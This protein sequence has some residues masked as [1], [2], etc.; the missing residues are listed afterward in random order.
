V[1][2]F[3]VIAALLLALAPRVAHACGASGPGGIGVG[4]S[5]EEHAEETRAHWRVG[6][7]YAYTS[8]SVT[9][10]S[11]RRADEQR[12]TAVATL[13]WMPTARVTLQGGVGAVLGGGLDLA[14]TRHDFQPGFAAVAGASWRIVDAENARPFVL[15]GTQ[16]SFAAASTRSAG[17]PAVSYTA[18]DVCLGAASGWVIARTFS[19][20]ALARVFGGPIFW[21]IA[22]DS[23]TGTDVYHYQLGAGLALVVA[24]RID[25]YVEGAALG[26]RAVAAGLGVSF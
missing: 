13:D 2:V 21:S 25:L 14:T 11:N 22:N 10:D 4:C 18:L 5:L 16:I 20:Y 26:E 8:T 17:F 9:F 12:H 15:L 19:A 6:A 1:R 24:R 3:V 23:V 7:G